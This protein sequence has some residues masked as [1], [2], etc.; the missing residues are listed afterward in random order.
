MSRP[1]QHCTILME[2]QPQWVGYV[3]HMPDQRLPKRLSTLSYSKEC[4]LMEAKEMLHKYSKNVPHL[5]S[6]LTPVSK[7][8]KTRPNGAFPVTKAL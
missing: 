1:V 3:A 5:P 8:P 2:S 6:N 7:V 4:T